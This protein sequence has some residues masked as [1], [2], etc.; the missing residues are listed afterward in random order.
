MRYA[1]NGVVTSETTGTVNK[2]LADQILS[3]RK[4]AIA[5]NKQ[6]ELKR[7][8]K[9]TFAT[10]SKIYMERHAIP[11]KKSWKKG[12]KSNLAN[13]VPCF[14]KKYLFEITPFMIEG[15]KAAREKKIK[16]TSI[17]RELAT[18]NTIFNKAIKWGFLTRNPMVD[19][20]HYRGDDHDRQ[21]VRYLELNEIER[22]VGCC[23]DPKLK[24]I[25]VLALNT[26]LR[27]G[28]IQRLQWNELDLEKE[29]LTVA[30]SKNNT[31]RYIPLNIQASMALREQPKHP[32]SLVVFPGED[33]KPYNFRKAF[34]T[35]L[36]RAEICD[37]RFHDLRHTFASH[38]VMSG[39]SI[40]TVMTLMGHH[41][42][43]M[44]QRYSHL[45]PDFNA[46]AVSVLDTRMVCGF[47]PAGDTKS[48]TV[49][50]LTEKDEKANI[51]T[52][53]KV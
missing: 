41:S 13:L 35:A 53:L 46:R 33:G 48:D 45:S 24:R 42:L 32:Y 21:R 34:E 16:R 22:L 10:L 1:K 8:Q 30:I 14:G 50:S 39:V 17:T 23:E 5:E 44:T 4:A 9:F 6:L 7:G 25:I 47:T 28:E 49:A 31:R 2:K 52:S 36:K 43:K 15:Y 40:Y 38:L 11:F 51:V 27:K 12:D 37:F 19:V 26:G 18:L 20:E 29:Q 3:K